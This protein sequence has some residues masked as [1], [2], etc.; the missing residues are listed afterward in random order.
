MVAVA[1]AGLGIFVSRELLP[2]SLFDTG[3]FSIAIF[4]FYLAAQRIIYHHEYSEAQQA[5][6]RKHLKHRTSTVVLNFSTAAVFIIAASIFLPSVADGIATGMGWGRSFVGSILMALATT[7]PELVVS[8]SALRL[9]LPGMALGNFY[10]STVFNMGIIF[11]DDIFYPGSILAS[12]SRSHLFTATLCLCM[13]AV[14]LVG[15]L[16]PTKSKGLRFIGW[17]AFIVFVLY[18]F[19]AFV[20][21]RLGSG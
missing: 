19:G 1:L 12:A 4:V 11:V 7:M 21:F 9:G 15:L 20:L 16:F 18:F 5:E 8:V 2:V 14:S 10:G 6:E 3:I 13:M 17:D